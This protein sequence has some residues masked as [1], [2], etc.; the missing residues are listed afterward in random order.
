MLVTKQLSDS[1]L[2]E[3]SQEHLNQLKSSELISP[4]ER[5]SHGR[6]ALSSGISLVWD[7]SV[8]I[9][10]TCHCLRDKVWAKYLAQELF[11]MLTAGLGLEPLTLVLVDAHLSPE[12]FIP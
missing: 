12:P 6:F 10:L 9:V 4:S 8:R 3:E 5:L 1:Q 2:V 7:F 11:H